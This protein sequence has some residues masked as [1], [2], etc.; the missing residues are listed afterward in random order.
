MVAE[1]VVGVAP[2]TSK[3][4]ADMVESKFLKEMQ[5]REKIYNR[6]FILNNK[7]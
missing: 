7:E 1:V 2:I 4:V 5:I 3:E 6:I